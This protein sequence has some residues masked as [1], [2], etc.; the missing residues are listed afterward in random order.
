MKKRKQEGV[1]RETGKRMLLA[2]LGASGLTLVYFLWAYHTF[3]F[4]YDI[5]DDVAMRN[6][7]AGVITG[8]P[9]AHLIHIKFVLE[10][11]RASCRER[12]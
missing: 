10:I 12:V 7:A 5:N 4:L 3:P 6:V 2:F 8:V 9:D 1:N 11:G